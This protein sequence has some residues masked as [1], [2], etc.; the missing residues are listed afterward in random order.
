MHLPSSALGVTGSGLRPLTTILD[1]SLLTKSSSFSSA[2]GAVLSSNTAIDYRL[3]MLLPFQLPKLITVPPTIGPNL[4]TFTSRSYA[5]FPIPFSNGGLPLSATFIPR[6][7]IPFAHLRVASDS[8]C[9][10]LDTPIVFTPSQDQTLLPIGTFICFGSFLSF[11]DLSSI[12]L[13]LAYLC[14]S[15]FPHLT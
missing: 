8:I 7:P 3:V 4:L 13:F 10:V 1:C 5:I 14:V 2:S 15:L 12:M 9:N 6:S 11:F